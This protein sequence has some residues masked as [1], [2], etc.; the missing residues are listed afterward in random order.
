MARLVERP[1]GAPD[2]TR[3]PLAARVRRADLLAALPVAG[4][5]GDGQDFEEGF[6]GCSS[7]G[8]KLKALRALVQDIYGN[9]FRPAKHDPRD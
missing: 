7:G 3:E 6:R 9:P 8:S 4:G 2:G 5:P 1:E